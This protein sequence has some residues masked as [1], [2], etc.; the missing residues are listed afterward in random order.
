[1]NGELIV[2]P[3]QRR[4]AG[5]LL[6]LWLLYGVN[7]GLLFAAARVCSAPGWSGGSAA[8]CSVGWLLLSMSAM[9]AGHEGAHWLAGR[10]CSLHSAHLQF[11]QGGWPRPRYVVA[12]QAG[13][14][15]DGTRRAVYLAGPWCDQLF[16]LAQLLLLMAAAP[17][18]VILWPAAFFA[19]FS[20]F[21]NLLALDDSDLG[22]ALPACGGHASVLRYWN[23]SLLPGALALV[24]AML[25]AAYRFL[26]WVQS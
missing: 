26:M 1:M 16:C 7:G 3:R 5:Q 14:Q 6:A 8:A 18:S 25:V 20:S 21:F 19:C 11:W 23:Y 10:I 9:V 4:G 13:L 2:W 24:A 22:Q 15:C 12:P 17:V